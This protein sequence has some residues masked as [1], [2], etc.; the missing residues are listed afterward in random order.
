M[1]VAAISSDNHHHHRRSLHGIGLI[2]TAV[3][4]TASSDPAIG[5]LI[6][7]GLS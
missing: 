4:V 2:A 6:V 3:V 5:P 7:D 1:E